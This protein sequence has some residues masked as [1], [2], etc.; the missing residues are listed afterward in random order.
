MTDE[1][2]EAKRA[3]LESAERKAKK[4]E[5]FFHHIPSRDEGLMV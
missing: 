5:L 3:A 1:I 4:D 2:Q